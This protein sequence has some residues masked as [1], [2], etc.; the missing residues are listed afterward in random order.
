MQNGTRGT[1]SQN[2]LSHTKE[3]GT[4]LLG[5][6][7]ELERSRCQGCAPGE[8][9][10]ASWQDHGQGSHDA[11]AVLLRRNL[12]KFYACNL[13][14]IFFCLHGRLF[15][16][17]ENIPAVLLDLLFW[18]C[19]DPLTPLPPFL[20][21]TNVGEANGKRALS[22][23]TPLARDPRTRVTGVILFFW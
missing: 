16:H 17:A 21:R 18:C 8:Q 20:C 23:R 15:L 6:A 4:S 2:W 3:Q 11:V 7:T 14:K 9:T 19:E 5:G 12:N 1:S 13:L 10:S 22:E